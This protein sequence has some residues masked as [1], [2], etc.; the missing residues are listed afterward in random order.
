VHAQ[1]E[2]EGKGKEGE[3]ETPSSAAPT[4]G[5]ASI[6]ACNC[7]GIV[8]AYHDKLPM[9]PTVKAITGARK[10]AMLKRWQWVLTERRDDGSTRAADAAAALDWFARFF[11]RAQHNDFIMG[12]TPRSPGHENWRAD[13]DFLLSDKGL[14]QVLEKTEVPS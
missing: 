5:R 1:A 2:G 9:L 4:A 11:E 14:L 12:R 13:L 10:K 7:E 6:P 8:N 3:G